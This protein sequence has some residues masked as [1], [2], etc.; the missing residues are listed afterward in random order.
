[1]RLWQR[2]NDNSD[3]PAISKTNDANREITCS[4][5]DEKAR[6]NMA[7]YM[8]SLSFGESKTE[9]THGDEK[10]NWK[11]KIRKEIWDKLENKEIADFPRPVHHRIPNF[12]GSQAANDN[13]A[14]LPEF[15]AAR[16]VK[17][18]PDTPQKHIRY[19]TLLQDKVLLVPQPRLRTGFFSQ[20]SRSNIPFN[21]LNYACTQAG[22]QQYGVPIGFDD[23][24]PKVDMII[25]G[26]CAVDPVSGARLGKGEGFAELEYG[27]LRMMGVVDDNTIVVTSVHDEQLIQ[28]IDTLRLL[29]HDVPVDIICT[30]TQII[31][32]NTQIPKPTGIYWELLSP[33]KLGQIKV[34]QHLKRKIEKETGQTLPLGASELLPPTAQ[35][36]RS[37]HP[38]STRRRLYDES[39]SKKE[40]E[41]GGNIQSELGESGS[42]KL[43]NSHFQ[44]FD[45]YVSNLKFG[46]SPETLQS[47]I[48]ECAEVCQMKLF[49][50]KG[51]AFVK[52]ADTSLTDLCISRLHGTDLVER[53]MRVKKFC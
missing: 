16:C 14:S 29:K 24:L 22:V 32:T 15:Q 5:L 40:T 48:S 26:S 25:I 51:T 47:C 3:S 49:Q 1:M 46:I 17:V 36:N 28:G 9:E 50:K 20:L 10:G 31:R 23:P 45:L 42:E 38:R 21:K 34:L 53:K 27:M 7:T 39:S 41:K 11:W 30:P 2:K 12:K 35:K 6:E 4:Q 19:L 13:I 37:T 33:E 52:L 43:K 44:K 18:N 8:A